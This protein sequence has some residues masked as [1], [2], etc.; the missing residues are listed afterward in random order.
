MVRPRVGER[1][2]RE[3]RRRAVLGL[4][5]VRLMRMMEW[6]LVS[7]GFLGGRPLLASLACDGWWTG[8]LV[9]V[10]CW[11]SGRL[12]LRRERPGGND[13][14]GL[15]RAS[16]SRGSGVKSWMKRRGGGEDDFRD[17]KGGVCDLRCI[18]LCK[19]YQQQDGVT[20]V[21][22]RLLSVPL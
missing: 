6:L 10:G 2:R 11:G 20:N 5:R 22:I 21:L 9:L 7:V 8:G 14:F 16:V 12:R 18:T 1:R 19:N 3:A 4:S 13:K 15:W 17:V